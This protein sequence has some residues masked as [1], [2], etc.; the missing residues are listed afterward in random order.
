[1]SR[2]LYIRTF[3]CQMNEYDSAKMADVLYAASGLEITD[4]PDDADVILFNTCS[5]REKAQERVFS[6]TFYSCPRTSAFLRTVG[7][8]P[9]NVNE[10]HAGVQAA[11][12]LGRG[13]RDSISQALV[14]S[15][16]HPGRGHAETEE[17]GV[18]PAKIRLDL[19]ILKQIRVDNLPELGVLH[20]GRRT[21]YGLDSLD[22]GI[23]QAL[24]K[25]TL[26]D[27]ARGSED[28]N[29]HIVRLTLVSAKRSH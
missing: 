7:S 6:F 25:D 22:L 27:H 23:Q 15:F 11:Q 14:F 17:A 2:K 5:V 18:E 26:A 13:D 16:G 20:P 10:R 29:V 24:P 21:S 28:Q 4:R 1:M 3:G 8:C 19:P 12:T 9:R